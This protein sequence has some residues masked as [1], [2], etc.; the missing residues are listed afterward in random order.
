VLH[1]LYGIYLDNMT[2]TSKIKAEC[3]GCRATGI[4]CGFAEPKGTG[5]VCVICNGTGCVDMTR[6]STEG[7]IYEPFVERKRRTDVNTVRLSAGRFMPTG[8]GPRGS[9]VSYEDFWNGKMPK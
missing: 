9:S 5:V 4:Y 2:H 3:G 7:I 6:K 8:L 1:P